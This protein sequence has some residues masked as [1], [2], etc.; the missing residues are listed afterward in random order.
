LSHP[1][2]VG[3]LCGTMPELSANLVA[4]YVQQVLS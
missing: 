3:K 4:N 1:C 2:P